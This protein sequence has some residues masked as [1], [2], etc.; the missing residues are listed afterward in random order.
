MI[1][2]FNLDLINKQP[3]TSFLKSTVHFLVRV[4]SQHIPTKL[5]MNDDFV[6]YEF[7]LS[8]Y[9]KSSIEFAKRKWIDTM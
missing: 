1:T 7:F 8:F 6:L 3:P 4:M 5:W 9:M 2:L